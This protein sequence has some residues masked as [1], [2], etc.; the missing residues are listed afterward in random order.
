MLITQSFFTF[1]DLEVR[2]IF[3]DFLSILNQCITE[4]NLVNRYLRASSV[5][6]ESGIN[7]GADISILPRVG[8][9]LPGFAYLIKLGP[10]TQAR[11]TIARKCAIQLI[12]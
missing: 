5:T 9:P 6:S 3:S 4:Q 12:S 11:E 8:G 10:T 7:L 2:L 1:Q